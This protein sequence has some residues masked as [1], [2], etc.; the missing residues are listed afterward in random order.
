MGDRET[1]VCTKVVILL[2]L[3][4]VYG[5]LGT[6]GIFFYLERTWLVI[7][8]FEWST[9]AAGRK[10]MKNNKKGR[11]KAG[12]EETQCNTS[13]RK[14]RGDTGSTA[15]RSWGVKL[16]TDSNQSMKNS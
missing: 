5:L 1:C 4:T 6:T 8:F 3:N 14:Q 16:M 15:L 11:G 9:A 7:F 13:R 12:G 10:N 2:C